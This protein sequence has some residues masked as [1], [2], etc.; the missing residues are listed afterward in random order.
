MEKYL[1]HTKSDQENILKNLFLIAS[2]TSVLWLSII[3]FTYIL[4]KQ[5]ILNKNTTGTIFF[6]NT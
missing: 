2:K 3:D 6:R 5:P 1:I 4:Q